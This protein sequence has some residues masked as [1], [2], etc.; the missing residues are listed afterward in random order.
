MYQNLKLKFIIL[1]IFHE[2]I[3]VLV[4][5]QFFSVMFNF[6][7]IS[8]VFCFMYLFTIVKLSGTMWW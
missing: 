5:L 2:N 3:L 7:I 1:I 8:V 6:I 4:Q